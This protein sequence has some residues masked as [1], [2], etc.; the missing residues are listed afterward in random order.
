MTCIWCRTQVFGVLFV[1]AKWHWSE[2]FPVGAF[3]FSGLCVIGSSTFAAGAILKGTKYMLPLMLLG[4]LIFGS[5]NGS[6]TSECHVWETC[7][8]FS[9]LLL[10]SCKSY[11][12]FLSVKKTTK[13]NVIIW[14]HLARNIIRC[15]YAKLC[16]KIIVIHNNWTWWKVLLLICTFTEFIFSFLFSRTKQNYFVLV[17]GQRVGDGIRYHVGVL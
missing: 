9:S 6:L 3:I 5:G 12:D 1:F 17:Q 4:R 13:C 11:R 2:F 10:S 8:I 7:F 15:S 16:F 14:H